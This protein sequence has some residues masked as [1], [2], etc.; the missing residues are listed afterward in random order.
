M[1]G[2]FAAQVCLRDAWPA[3]ETVELGGWLIRAGKGGYNR[4]NSVWPG[5]FTGEMSLSRAIEAVETFYR[6]RGLPPRFQMLDIVQPIDLE[7]V[8]ERRGYLREL[9]CSD[10]WKAVTATEM[11]P[12]VSVT[13]VAPPD[14]LS[15]FG[16]HQSLEKSAEYPEI[17]KRL[18]VGRGFLVCRRDGQPHGVALVGHAGTDVAVDCVL[19]RPERRRS[20]VARA[21]L[22]AADA[23]AAKHHA[24]RL[25]LSVVDD[26]L[27]AMSL[28]AGLGYRKLS[29]YH[30][31]FKTT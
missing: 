26:N 20:G 1:D 13:P 22:V 12:D 9:A 24:Q 16:S 4:V 11:P 29:A 10:M 19:T 30:Y 6:E 18:P 27:P 3:L 23:W 2:L 31:R 15:L 5:H 14:W 8:L 17:L 25:I 7:R 28:Y 21:L